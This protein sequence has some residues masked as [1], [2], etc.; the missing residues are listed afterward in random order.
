M[1]IYESHEFF[2]NACDAVVVIF[3]AASVVLNCGRSM[4]QPGKN[5]VPCLFCIRFLSQ[6]PVVIRHR[7][8]LHV[9]K[10]CDTLYIF[11][12]FKSVF[13]TY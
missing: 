9:G 7:S 10:K 11:F 1:D 2:V 12:I 3:P 5:N 6:K 4:T 13:A 8:P